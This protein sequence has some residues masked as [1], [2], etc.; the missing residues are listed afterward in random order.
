MSDFDL[1]I[2]FSCRDE[3]CSQDNLNVQRTLKEKG[4]IFY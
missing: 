1:S 2:S 4:L 3:Q